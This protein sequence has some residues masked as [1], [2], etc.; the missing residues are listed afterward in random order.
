M[1]NF[2]VSP[3]GVRNMLI[4]LVL[5]IAGFILLTGGGSGDPNVFNEGMFDARKLVVAPIVILLGITIVIIGIMKR[6][7]DKEE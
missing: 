5:M 6:P 7:K 1:S 4:G 3:K 2:S